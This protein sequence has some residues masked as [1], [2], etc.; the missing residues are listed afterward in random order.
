MAQDR[1][2]MEMRALECTLTEEERDA[3]ARELARVI[4]EERDQAAAISKH[5][6]EAKE[7]QKALEAHLRELQGQRMTLATEVTSRR[8]RRDVKCLWYY[9]FEGNRKILVRTDTGSAVARVKLTEEERQLALG[10]LLA[11]ATDEQI[12]RWDRELQEPAPSDEEAVPT[13][14]EGETGEP[15]EAE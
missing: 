2:R 1:E 4:M 10:E 8:V 11:E 15:E 12:Q 3:K 13:D 6:T 9:D 14:G 7:A 5:Q